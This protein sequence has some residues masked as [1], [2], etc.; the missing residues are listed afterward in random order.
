MKL[1]NSAKHS[2]RIC[3]PSRTIEVPA[4]GSVDVSKEE[5]TAL[6]GVA[7]I[8]ARFEANTLSVAA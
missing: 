8:R 4:E 1:K 2:L 5:A 7:A 6:Q 3:L